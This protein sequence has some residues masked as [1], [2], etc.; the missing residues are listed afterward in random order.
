METEVKEV[1]SAEFYFL[2]RSLITILILAVVIGCFFVFAA[3]R[4]ESRFA[5]RNAKNAL[6][7]IEAVGIEHRGNGTPIF[8]E[9]SRD[10][11]V[12]GVL[13]E[14]KKLSGCDGEIRIIAYD[15]ET[16]TVEKMSYREKNFLVSYNK[17]KK[18]CWKLELIIELENL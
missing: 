17:N 3:L 4:A 1:K 8:T 12:D 15:A 14:V 18:K 13:K 16:N 5:L 9:Y 2:K 10:G 11:F 7:A 6:F